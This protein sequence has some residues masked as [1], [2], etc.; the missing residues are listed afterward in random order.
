MANLR[1]AAKIERHD[2]GHVASARAC[3]PDSC[4][5]NRIEPT[6][7]YL[8]RPGGG[9]QRGR[10]GSSRKVKL[11]PLRPAFPHDTQGHR[12]RPR[13]TQRAR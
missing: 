1:A 9:R 10:R 6:R 4:E 5:T 12:K 2:I 7:Q 13:C 11:E 8:R 3:T